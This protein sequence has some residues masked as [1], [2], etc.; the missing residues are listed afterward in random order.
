MLLWCCCCIGYGRERERERFR[1]NGLSCRGKSQRDSERMDWAAKEISERLRVKT[2][3]FRGETCG[4]PSIP[5]IEE[6]DLFYKV[7]ILTVSG[8]DSAVFVIS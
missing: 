3:R 2:E 6:W 7:W 5:M 4:M 8:N 1:E